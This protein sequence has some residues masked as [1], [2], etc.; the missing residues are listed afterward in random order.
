MTNS[1]KKTQNTNDM[2][3]VNVLGASY[4]LK[5]NS[6]LGGVGYKLQ[7]SITD[8]FAQFVHRLVD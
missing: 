7:K 2:I 8:R 4:S 5:K 1:R 3:S 6:G